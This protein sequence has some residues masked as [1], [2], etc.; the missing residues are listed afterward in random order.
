MIQTEF[1]HD[2]SHHDAHASAAPEVAPM[3][4]ARLRRYAVAELCGS[5]CAV[6]G[7][8]L[9]HALGGNAVLVA[10][11]GTLGENLGYYGVIVS[12][13][14]RTGVGVLAG[15]RNLPRLHRVL[16]VLKREQ[17]NHARADGNFRFGP[18]HNF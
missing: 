10:V 12:R 17:D 5:V 1:E 11:G 18:C 15:V 3:S 16:M 6:A 4:G 13:E 14:L 9:M 7:A 8:L 2:P